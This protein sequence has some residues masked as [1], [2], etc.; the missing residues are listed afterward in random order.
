MEESTFWGDRYPLLHNDRFCHPDDTGYKFETPV[1]TR[2]AL[3]N[4]TEDGILH[5]HRRG[6]LKSYINTFVRGHPG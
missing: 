4:I 6:T 1:F 2:T 3:R 5:S